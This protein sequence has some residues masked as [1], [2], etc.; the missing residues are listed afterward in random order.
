MKIAFFG[1]PE[2][3]SLALKTLVEQKIGKVVLAV[4]Q[5][6][7][8]VGRKKVDTPPA[9]K[10]Y[11]EKVGIPVFQPEKLDDEAV[12][13][14]LKHRADVGVMVA[15]GNLIPKKLI[16]GFTKGIVNIH[17]SLLP[18]H[19]GATPVASAILAGDTETGVSLMVID[20]KLDHGPII[21]QRKYALK[22]DETTTA[23]LESLTPIALETLVDEFVQYL[24][25]SIEPK[26]QDDS[27]STF[28]KVIKNAD[29]K[30]DW[31]NDVT[32][33]ERM[34]R[35]MHGVLPAWSSYALSSDRRKTPNTEK[36]Q[37][38]RARVFVQKHVLAPGTLTLRENGLA[39]AAKDGFLLVLELQLSGGKPMSGSA[40][41]NGHRGL[42]G[43]VLS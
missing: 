14:I 23:L 10:T 34:V 29:A 42:I 6:D 35:A 11:A 9:V 32:Q 38:H 8:P 43:T 33:I 3:A 24:D 20:D 1:T 2:F 26:P 39:I 25:G 19:R 21:G 40:F 18:R 30:I 28:S 4:T 36:L 31:S 22:G 17:P 12:E 5:P 13:S 37:I 27:K 7:R 41:L 15:Y 16:A